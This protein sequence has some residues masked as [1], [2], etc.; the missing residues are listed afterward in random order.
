MGCT[1]RDSLYAFWCNS[2]LQYT[3]CDW[4]AH[5]RQYAANTHFCCTC[6]QCYTAVDAFLET[7]EDGLV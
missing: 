7:T 2:D 1:N 6:P 5:L 4:R 3:F